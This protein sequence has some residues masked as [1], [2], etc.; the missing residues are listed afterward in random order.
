M[1]ELREEDPYLHGF[2]MQDLFSNLTNIMGKLGL[3]RLKK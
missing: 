3:D 2:V 1:G